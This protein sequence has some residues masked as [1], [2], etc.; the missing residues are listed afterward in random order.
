MTCRHPSGCLIFAKSLADRGR[1][2]LSPV[3]ECPL[4]WA[5]HAYLFDGLSVI[6][7]ETNGNVAHR[8]RRLLSDGNDDLVLTIN[9]SGYSLNSQVGREWGLDAGSAVLLSNA[10]LGGQN[11]P[12]RR[13]FSVCAFRAAALPAWSLP[14]RTH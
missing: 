6:M 13:P 9:R 8:T 3:G 10:E 11:F 5:V 1:A 2:Q 4:K 14:Q 7:G 12:R